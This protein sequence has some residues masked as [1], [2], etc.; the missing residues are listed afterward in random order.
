MTSFPDLLGGA[1][2]VHLIPHVDVQGGGSYFPGRTAWWARGG[3]RLTILDARDDAH[4]G[5]TWRVAA[6]LGYRAVSDA[7]GAAAG[8]TAML[9]SDLAH[10]FAPHLGLSVQMAMGALYDDP[11]KRW[12]PELR[13]GV[14][15]AF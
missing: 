12:L 13:L 10:F 9:S 15:L 11:N 7:R 1:V 3:P 6:L 2:T 5:L 8:F 14:G 4:R